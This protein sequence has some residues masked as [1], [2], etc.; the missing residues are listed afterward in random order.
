MDYERF[1]DWNAAYQTCR[2]RERSIVAIVGTETARIWPNGEY[3]LLHSELPEPET[4]GE[5]E[6]L[7]EETG[8]DGGDRRAPGFHQPATPAGR[9]QSSGGAPPG[10]V[11]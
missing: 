8:F 5:Q 6:S 7:I 1:T 3:Q 4:A 10:G 9:G 2:R 11:D